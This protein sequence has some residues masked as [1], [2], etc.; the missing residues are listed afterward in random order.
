MGLVFPGCEIT[1][2]CNTVLLGDSTSV[3]LEVSLLF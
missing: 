2:D 1:T 3:E